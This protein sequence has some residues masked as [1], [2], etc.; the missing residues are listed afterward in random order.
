MAILEKEGCAAKD[1]KEANKI[2]RY[3]L[4]HQI[5]KHYQNKDYGDEKKN[6]EILDNKYSYKRYNVP[7]DRGYDI[8]NM[9]RINKSQK[10]NAKLKHNITEWDTICKNSNGGL[11][12]NYTTYT[13]G[14]KHRNNVST[15]P[16]KG[17]KFFI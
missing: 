1:L 11:K 8:V 15:I 17:K 14:M 3:S 6:K 4:R 5:E 10:E 13:D 7:E 12:A 2:K 9:E 16:N